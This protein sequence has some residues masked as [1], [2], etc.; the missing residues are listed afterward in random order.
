MGSSPDDACPDT[1]LD[2]ECDDACSDSD[3]AF[4]L[5][6]LAHGTLS[7]DDRRSLGTHLLGC[8][9]C[10]IMLIVCT[11]EWETDHHLPKPPQIIERWR[12][13]AAHLWASGED[14]G[15]AGYTPHPAEREFWWRYELEQLEKKALESGWTLDGEQDVRLQ[16]WL[17]QIGAIAQACDGLGVDIET[18]WTRPE[19]RPAR[20]R[21]P[22]HAGR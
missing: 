12:T 18:E 4:Y 22:K 2:L 16:H 8:V 11:V 3:I 5:W 1:E 7:L 6:D 15:D 20:K 19:G 17:A 21:V 10:Q 13:V 14:D 9:R